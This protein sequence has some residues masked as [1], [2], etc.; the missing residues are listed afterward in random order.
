MELGVTL[1]VARVIHITT[2]FNNQQP[3]TDNQDQQPTTNNKRPTTLPKHTPCIHY[4]ACQHFVGGTGSRSVPPSPGGESE[5]WTRRRCHLP[6]VS[7]RPGGMVRSARDL[8][9]GLL[10]KDALRT[11]EGPGREPEGKM[12]LATRCH[13]VPLRTATTTV[14][15][16]ACTTTMTT[17][18]Q[19]MTLTIQ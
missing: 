13:P 8:H 4:R 16:P 6:L 14:P 17:T 9:M 10:K 2:D 3:T 7:L 12:A 18:Q 15:V 5:A 19:R 1:P 11:L